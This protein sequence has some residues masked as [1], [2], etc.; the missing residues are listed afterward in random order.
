MGMHS[1]VLGFREP[2][3]KWHQMKS[4]WDACKAADIDSPKEVEMFFGGEA[5]DPSGIETP[6]SYGKSP[7]CS[8]Y[9][10]DMREGFEIDISKLP[11]N[12]TKIRFVNAY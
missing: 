1:Y 11:D 4:V 12:I 2:D 6:L 10:S 9:K 8:E 5:P 3:E 7:C